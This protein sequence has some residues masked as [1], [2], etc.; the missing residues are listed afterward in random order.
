MDLAKHVMQA[1]FGYPQFY[2]IS[3]TEAIGVWI[4]TPRVTNNDG[5]VTE[6]VRKEISLTVDFVCCTP[7]RFRANVTELPNN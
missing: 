4:V 5:S 3:N 6:E 1:S 7:E 2:D